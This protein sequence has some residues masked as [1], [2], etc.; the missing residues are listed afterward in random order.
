MKERVLVFSD[1]IIAIVLTIMVLELPIH[2]DAQGALNYHELGRAIGIYF[3]SFCFVADNWYETAYAFNKI[4]HVRNKV[5]IA[6]LF[7][8]FLLSLV[9]SA[10]RLLIDDTTKETMMIYGVLTLLVVFFTRRLIVNLTKQA[11][12]DRVERKHRV[13]ELNRQDI[14]LVAFRLILLVLGYY[15]I[16]PTLVIYLFLPIFAFLQNVVDRE[17]DTLVADLNQTERAEYYRDRGTVWDNPAQRYSWFLKN[18]IKDGDPYDPEWRQHTM[19][20]MKEKI[21]SEIQQKR[22]KLAAATDE[23]IRRRLEREIDRLQQTAEKF[24]KRYKL[25][26]QQ[27][28]KRTENIALREKRDF[29]K[30]NKR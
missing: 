2:Y 25:Q 19:D 15:F 8:L 26:E 24:E 7:I 27:L 11:L 14:F 28:A 30:N 18:A 10:T 17:E 23:K 20:E 3:I 16:R 5:L 1:A 9:P 13:D 6:Y 21:Q 4:Q 12:P 22:T 29:D